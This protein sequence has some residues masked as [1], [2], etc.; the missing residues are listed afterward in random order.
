M[1]ITLGIFIHNFP[2]GMATFVGTLQSIKLGIFLAFTIAL[3][4][5]PE[6]IAVAIPVY[7][8]TGSKK[9]LLY[10]QLCQM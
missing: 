3:H 10:G 4:N 7:T 2:E 1:L 6:G 9:K 8:S 5:I